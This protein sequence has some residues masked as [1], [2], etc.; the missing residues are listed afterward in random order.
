MQH[1]WETLFHLGFDCQGFSL[2][3]HHLFFDCSDSLLENGWVKKTG[4]WKHSSVGLLHRHC[5]SGW[6]CGSSEW[7]LLHYHDFL[8]FINLGLYSIAACLSVLVQ[9]LH[10]IELLVEWD[11][12]LKHHAAIL[13][14]NV[15]LDWCSTLVPCLLLIHDIVDDLAHLLLIC[16]KHLNLA[17]H[18]LSLAVH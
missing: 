10:V 8:E 11:H 17:L 9:E 14:E 4:I 5:L 13:I 15:L 16:L 7:I 12:H 18:E 2:N 1:I 3:I 6:L